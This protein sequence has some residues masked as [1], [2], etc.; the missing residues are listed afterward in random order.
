MNTKKL[1]FSRQ[2]L[3]AMQA[4]AVGC[5]GIIAAFYMP[6]FFIAQRVATSPA[7]HVAHHATPPFPR[8]GLIIS[9]AVGAL[10]VYAAYFLWLGKRL[11]YWLSLGIISVFVLASFVQF[12][13]SLLSIA[14]AALAVWLGVSHA[15]YTVRSSGLRIRSGFLVAT[16]IL[17][18]GV[19]YGVIALLLISHNKIG[20]EQAF[21]DTIKLSMGNS[22]QANI[23]S[24]PRLLNQTSHILVTCTVFAISSVLIGLF[25]PIR[26]AFARDER[27]RVLMKDLIE[28]YGTSSEDF[29]KIWPHD[30]YY[31]FNNE[32]TCAVAYGVVRHSVII[33]GSPVGEENKKETLLKQFQEFC[34]TAGWRIVAVNLTARDR[35]IYEKA[36][37]EN[38]LFVGNEALVN[39]DTFVEK[40]LRSK[41]FRYIM[42]RAKKHQLTVEFWTHP[43]RLQLNELAVV[44]NAWKTVGGR[45]EFRFFMSPFQKDYLA[46]C[47]IAVVRQ[48]GAIIAYANLLPH[49]PTVKTS[50]IDHMRAL[51]DAD[52]ST[53]H[54]LL[55][56]VIMHEHEAGQK[57]FTL[58]LSPLH[59]RQNE[60]EKM[61]A[62]FKFVKRYGSRSYAF[63]GLSQF[64]NKFEPDWQPQ[65]ISYSGPTSS[66]LSVLRDIDTI[67]TVDTRIR[68]RL[69]LLMIA[70]VVIS[71][72]VYIY[73][74]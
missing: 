22:I 60:T 55:A 25:R 14:A 5:M 66:Y 34:E 70:T 26:F 41:H 30:K 23:Y 52:L 27:H 17:F 68:Q 36:G 1:H 47:E 43:T 20:I 11:A 40:T 19:L 58:G 3:R 38:T 13:I 10:L 62:V 35:A 57:Y 56:H 6:I 16:I 42:N 18:F 50:S 15:N 9:I 69:K 44:S 7:L 31:F 51:P 8:S 39:T 2:Q 65:Y 28:E 24:H 64:K 59:E 48:A 61:K 21:V 29:L 73:L 72:S 67:S 71:A 12:R 37:I 74:T 32:Q 53:M 4:I 54:F 49:A 46:A 33:L 63:N 45:K